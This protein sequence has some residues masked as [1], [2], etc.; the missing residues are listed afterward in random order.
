VIYD[1]LSLCLEKSI[2][3]SLSE[4]SRDSSDSPLS[5]ESLIIHIVES[6][7]ELLREDPT[8]RRLASTRWPYERD[9]DFSHEREH[10]R[11]IMIILRV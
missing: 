3:S 8:Y 10:M 11:G 1:E 7:P 4:Y 6:H 2:I 9:T 5:L